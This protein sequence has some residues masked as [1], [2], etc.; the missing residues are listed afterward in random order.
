MFW[1]RKNTPSQSTPETHDQAN[2][3]EAPL[4]FEPTSFDQVTSIQYQFFLEP[5]KPGQYYRILIAKFSGEYKLGSRGA[6]DA[7]FICGITKT[8]F[9][10]WYPDGL[11]LDLRE[12]SYGW[13][14]DMDLVLDIG[15]K[16]GKPCAIVGSHRCLPAIATLINGVDTDKLATDTEF[17]FDSM[18]AALKFIQ[19][20]R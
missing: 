6:A 12:L 3:S 5:R 9:N 11:I 20:N 19:Q 4:G 17:I 1:K 2:S 7:R 13:G 14:D 10:I 15:A 8:A 18:D 16:T